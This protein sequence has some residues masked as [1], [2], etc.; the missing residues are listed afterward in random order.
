[1]SDT[2]HSSVVNTTKRLNKLRE[3]FSNY[4]ITAYIIPSE[5]SHQSEYVAACDARRSFI[6]G[7]TGSA[8]LAIVSNDAAALFTD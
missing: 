2:T 1:M 5:D 3:L 7:F 4:D 8:G 6:S